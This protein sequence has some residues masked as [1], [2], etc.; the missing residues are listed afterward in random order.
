MNENYLK[1]SDK[2]QLVNACPSGGEFE[3]PGASVVGEPV[4]SI[5][6]LTRQSRRTGNSVIEI[7]FNME[8]I[9]YFFFYK[10]VQL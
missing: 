4:V 5:F 6:W 2:Q 10:N 3:F 8:L 1:K 9:I 7:H